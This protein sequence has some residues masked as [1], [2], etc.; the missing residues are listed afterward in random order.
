MPGPRNSK[1]QKKMKEKK[2][3]GP[4]T[5]KV[6]VE[7]VAT[8][9]VD[10]DVTPV[11]PARHDA[12]EITAGV[13]QRMEF[14]EMEGVLLLREPPIYNGGTGPR[15][16]SMDDFL[17]SGFASEPTWDDEL[18]A[19]FAQEEMLEMLR[20]VLPEEMALVSAEQSWHQSA[21]GLKWAVMKVRVVQQE[22]TT[23]PGLSSLLEDFPDGGRFTEPSRGS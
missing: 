5:C 20:A 7:P 23:V 15:V 22:P 1:R 14:D 12:E 17:R 9:E 21:L 4:P 11:A 6:E 3:K 16:K 8:S 10:G 19:E 13:E 2:R 18:C